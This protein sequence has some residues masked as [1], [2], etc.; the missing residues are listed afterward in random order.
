MS[1]AIDRIKAIL[2]NHERTTEDEL[3]ILRRLYD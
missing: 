3:R 2:V 1:A